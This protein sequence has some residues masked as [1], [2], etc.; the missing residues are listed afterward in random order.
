MV[1]ASRNLRPSSNLIHMPGTGQ[2]YKTHSLWSA[3]RTG[4]TR[5]SSARRTHHG[6]NYSCHPIRMLYTR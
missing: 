4:S 1:S 5:P 3:I 6:T 2:L